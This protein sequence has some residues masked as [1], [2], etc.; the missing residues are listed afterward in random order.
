MV[1]DATELLAA[2]QRPAFREAFNA[3]IEKHQPD[4][5]R[6]EYPASRVDRRRPGLDRERR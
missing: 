4:F 1:T 5:H 2:T 3:P 6:S